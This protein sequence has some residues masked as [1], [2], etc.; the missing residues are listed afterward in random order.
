MTT[1]FLRYAL[2]L[3]IGVIPAHGCKKD[4]SEPDTKEAPATAQM[5]TAPASEEAKPAAPNPAPTKSVPGVPG[6]DL[7]VV[8]YD[9]NRKAMK[10]NNA[11]LKLHMKKKWDDAIAEYTEGLRDDPS[12]ILMRY[13][14]A[15]AY[16]MKG[17]REHALTLLKQ[18]Y[19]TPDCVDCE[20]RLH[21]ASEDSDWKAYW[22]DPEFKALTQKAAKKWRDKGDWIDYEKQAFKL[23]GE[24][25]KGYWGMLKKT[26]KA[27]RSFSVR[28]KAADKSSKHH[29]IIE[30]DSELARWK[31]QLRKSTEDLMGDLHK[32]LI[33][34]QFVDEEPPKIKCKASC[35]TFKG[36]NCEMEMGGYEVVGK[37]TRACFFA[38]SK[39]SIYVHRL[40]MDDYSVGL[41]DC[42]IDDRQKHCGI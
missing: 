38:T 19:G 6:L 3:T 14:L 9:Q 2:L 31:L 7:T 40:E 22:D 4:S 39:D 26:T 25:G 17:A 34:P 18:F 30:N 16:A 37:L 21:R 1:Q 23:A 28:R 33:C 12:H 11:A 36:G 5:P 10:H 32:P 27:G 13:N 35:C 24:L 8:S 42:A 29:M 15:C 41:V 20:L